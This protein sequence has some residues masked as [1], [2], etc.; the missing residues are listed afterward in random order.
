MTNRKG[1]NIP[2]PPC[3]FIS[4]RSAIVEKDIQFFKK[5][6]QLIDSLKSSED[7]MKNPHEKIMTISGINISNL[8]HKDTIKYLM[9]KEYYKKVEKFYDHS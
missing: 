4:I 7:N 6:P 3:N 8:L 1:L 5:A 2:E 9:E